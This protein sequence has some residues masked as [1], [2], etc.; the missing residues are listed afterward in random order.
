VVKSRHESCSLDESKNRLSA[1]NLSGFQGVGVY[2]D[3]D[4]EVF[5]LMSTTDAI[6]RSRYIRTG[7]VRWPSP[8]MLDGTCRN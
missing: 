6:L 1:T 8:E 3:E 4:K 5:S 2:M 7:F